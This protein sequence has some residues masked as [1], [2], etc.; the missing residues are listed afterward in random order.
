VA[1][2]SLLSDA[3]LRLADEKEKTNFVD[4]LVPRRSLYVMK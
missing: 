2:L 3:V 4:C 1:V